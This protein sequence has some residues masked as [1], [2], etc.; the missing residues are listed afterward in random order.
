MAPSS[1]PPDPHVLLLHDAFLRRLARGL[2]A[3]AADADDL[4]QATYERALAAY[5]AAKEQQ[6]ESVP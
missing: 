3:Q 5:R 1:P 4:V 2:V 6:A